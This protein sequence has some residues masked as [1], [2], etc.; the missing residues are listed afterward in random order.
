M[1]F[2]FSALF[3]T[4]AVKKTVT[5]LCLMPLSALAVTWYNAAEA[6]FALYGKIAEAPGYER[7]CTSEGLDA[8]QRAMG[9]CSSGMQIRFRTDS[10][11]IRIKAALTGSGAMCHIPATGQ[12]GMDLYMGVPGN[13]TYCRTTIFDPSKAGY[14]LEIY[15]RKER[16]ME[17]FVLYLPLYNGVRSLEIG[18]DDDAVLEAAAPMPSGSIAFFGTSITQGGCASRPGMSHTNIISRQL[19]CVVY[20]FGFSGGGTMEP[21]QLHNLI[22]AEDPRLFVIE[23]ENNCA[24]SV[25]DG[26]MR[27][28]IKN[29]QA[30]HPG[31]PVLIISALPG[32]T[33]NPDSAELQAQIAAEC[34]DGVYYLDGRTLLPGDPGEYTVDGLHLTTLGFQAYANSII[35][36]IE[37]LVQ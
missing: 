36:Y 27:D 34:G 30:A 9:K 26:R 31:V 20:N 18:L 21:A 8:N 6:P 15:K 14:E 10:A 5:A 11:S 29:I 22:K 16:T 24:Y 19:G 4:S 37:G 35:P 32:Y 33:V 23:C 1:K 7:L 17:D 12:S 2:I 28:F 13:E 3:K 25:I